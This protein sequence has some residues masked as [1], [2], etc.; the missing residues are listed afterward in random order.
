[1]E[2]L[3]LYFDPKMAGGHFFSPK[4]ISSKERVKLCFFVTFNIISQILP[5]NF[6]ETP[7]VVQKIWREMKNSSVNIS[8]LH[9]SYVN[10]SYLHRYSS[11]FGCSDICLSQRTQN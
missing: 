4:N 6:I 3:K 1:M 8:Y 11:I 5:E 10:I 7:Q 9:I 2:V